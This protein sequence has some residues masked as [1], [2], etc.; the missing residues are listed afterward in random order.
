MPDE[1]WKFGYQTVLNLLGFKDKVLDFG[2]G[3]GKFSRKLAELGMEVTGVDPTP[4]M[5]QF[6]KKQEDSNIDYHC[7]RDLSFLPLESLDAAVST[8][9]FCTEHDNKKIIRSCQEI[10][11]ALKP[12]TP[13][14]ILDPHPNI[15]NKEYSSGTRHLLQD[16]IVETKL[17]GMKN[18]FYDFHRTVE[19]YF[20][21]LKSC[22]FKI[23]EIREPGRKEPE[24]L[25]IKAMK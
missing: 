20:V 14:V 21:I 22:Q 3:S 17:D 13:F 18:S 15:L 4:K 11:A 12:N 8:F 1:D 25:V 23:D 9:V 24:Y 19:E 5:I 16:R 6:A 7:R 2:C 10:Y